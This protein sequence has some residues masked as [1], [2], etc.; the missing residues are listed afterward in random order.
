MLLRLM[1]DSDT[2]DVGN[3]GMKIGSCIG[4]LNNW[5]YHGWEG[6]TG[7]IMINV[8]LSLIAFVNTLPTRAKGGKVY[9]FRCVQ[10]FE[11]HPP[12]MHADLVASSCT[13]PQHSLDA[14]RSTSTGPK[15]CIS[16]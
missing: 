9:A 15:G 4:I 13:L 6:H 10:F 7:V 8:H 1:L 14:N 2:M 16:F 5:V 12:S 11:M 3:G